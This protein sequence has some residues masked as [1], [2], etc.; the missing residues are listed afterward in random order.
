MVGMDCD[1]ARELASADLDGQLAEPEVRLL[2]SHLAECDDCARFSA[3]AAS[4]TRRSRVGRVGSTVG[5]PA[6]PPRVVRNRGLRI[7]LGW[8]GVL[9]VALYLPHVLSAGEELAVHLARHQ[10]AFD[11]ALGVGFVFVAWKPDRAYGVVPLVAAF[12]VALVLVAV[13]DV[14]NGT[15]SA[16]IESRHLLELGGLVLMW[17][18]GSEMGPKP[19]VRAFLEHRFNGSRRP[20]R[21]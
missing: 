20:R 12:T 14:V 18:L 19:S 21:G 4:L 9:L 3:A 16:A 2:E 6:P 1:V 5:P 8:A 10:A 15:S 17:V 13:I 11:V 7:A